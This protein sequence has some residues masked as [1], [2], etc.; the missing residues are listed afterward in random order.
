MSNGSIKPPSEF[1]A[2]ATAGIPDTLPPAA[3]CIEPPMLPVGVSPKSTADPLSV[4]DPPV[5]KESPGL[6]HAFAASVTAPSH[7]AGKRFFGGA[8]VVAKSF[9]SWE[10]LERGA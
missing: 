1:A 8:T 4:I 10:P 2:A 7:S 6:A 9:P 3:P 5:M